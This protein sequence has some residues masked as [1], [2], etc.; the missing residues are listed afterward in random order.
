[1]KKSTD[2]RPVAARKLAD[3]KKRLLE[4]NKDAAV[5][6]AEAHAKDSHSIDRGDTF[7]GVKI[8]GGKTANLSS[9]GTA[10]QKEMLRGETAT[11]APTP[12]PRTILQKLQLKSLKGK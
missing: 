5:Q 12:K 4:M 3:A 1:M 6:H 10:Y 11:L 7:A 2:M 9:H 8:V